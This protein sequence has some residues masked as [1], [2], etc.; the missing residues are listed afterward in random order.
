MGLRLAQY[1]SLTAAASGKAAGKQQQRGSSE[2][3]HQLSAVGIRYPVSLGGE[4]GGDASCC[5]A[6]R[7]LL[8]GA[9]WAGCSGLFLPGRQSG[10]E[11]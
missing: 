4:V 8:P 11:K 10:E 2:P 3:G 6:T 7:S 9:G 5:P 1:P